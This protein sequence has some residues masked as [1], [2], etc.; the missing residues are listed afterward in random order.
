MY[1]SPLLNSNSHH[2][3]YYDLIKL[4]FN[5]ALYHERNLVFFF[6]IVRQLAIFVNEIEQAE[7]ASL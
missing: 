3:N 4:T 7:E 1:F 5:V 6:I 2:E